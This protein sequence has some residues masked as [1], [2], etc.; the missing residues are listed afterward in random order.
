MWAQLALEGGHMCAGAA[1]KGGPATQPKWGDPVMW[2]GGRP[3][4]ALVA[5]GERKDVAGGGVGYTP[6]QSLLNPGR[7]SLP[8]LGAQSC[9]GRGTGFLSGRSSSGEVENGPTEVPC[10]C[11]WSPSPTLLLSS[12]MGPEGALG[13]S[14]ACSPWASALA[15]NPPSLLPTSHSGPVW[16]G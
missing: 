5:L 14:R 15:G 12:Q 9:W 13:L 11:L 6:F 1:R 7:P 10:P 2:S 16:N 8:P 4:R 3:R